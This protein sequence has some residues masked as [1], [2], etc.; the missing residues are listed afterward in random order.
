MGR[1]L[2]GHWCCKGYRV[3]RL[4][5]TFRRHRQVEISPICGAIPHQSA[6]REWQCECEW[7]DRAEPARSWG[8]G[9]EVELQTT[10]VINHP[11]YDQATCGCAAE[12]LRLLVAS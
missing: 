2:A 7:A 10:S 1:H 12:S 9:D 11:G 4:R 8:G 3:A 6:L 5:R